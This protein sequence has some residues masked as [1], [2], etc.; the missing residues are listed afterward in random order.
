M[1]TAKQH[2]WI[3]RAFAIIMGLL[4]LWALSG[5]TTYNACKDPNSYTVFLPEQCHATFNRK[6]LKWED[7]HI[8]DDDE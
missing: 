4:L 6:V 5:C 3:L 1:I 8:G 7:V 2:A